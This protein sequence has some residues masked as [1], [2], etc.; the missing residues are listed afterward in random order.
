M[1]SHPC[2]DK[3]VSWMG[4]PLSCGMDFREEA[5]PFGSTCRFDYWR[6]IISCNNRSESGSAFD[7]SLHGVGVYQACL[8]ELK[9]AA[10]KYCEVRNAA[11]VE[12]RGELREP[13]CVDFEH[14]GLSRQIARDLRN[15]RSGHSAGTAPLGPEI[16]E[17]GNLAVANEL[18]EF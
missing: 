18:V 8:L 10:R 7:P 1:L 3:A 13:L 15:V 17:D 6:L 2:H 12:P 11:N 9:A 16:N 5:V 4:H 14:D